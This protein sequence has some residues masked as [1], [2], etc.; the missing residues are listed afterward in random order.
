MLMS[1]CRQ[2]GDW[3]RVPI[4]IEIVNDI[5][6]RLNIEYYPQSICCGKVPFW[7]KI[8]MLEV[9]PELRDKDLS[10]ME[11]I[12]HMNVLKDISKHSK[13]KCNNRCNL[14][15]SFLTCCYCD[16]YNWCEDK[17][18][19]IMEMDV[20]LR[21]WQNS[22]NLGMGKVLNIYMKLKSLRTGDGSIFRWIAFALTPAEI[23]KLKVEPFL[24]GIIHHSTWCG[25]VDE[26][27][28]CM[29]P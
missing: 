24:N 3:N 22:F 13:S 10:K 6:V 9:P 17:R 18:L 19:H 5:V 27:D 15:C 12:S 2:E 8:D 7:H 21:K 16:S 28:L 1:R 25:D 23:S 11:W 4:R 14:C 20:L 26:A 29:F